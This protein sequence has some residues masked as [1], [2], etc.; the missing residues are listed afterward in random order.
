[1]LSNKY[2]KKIPPSVLRKF[3]LNTTFTISF[4]TEKKCWVR[5]FKNKRKKPKGG[6]FMVIK[7]IATILSNASNRYKRT[8]RKF[9]IREIGNVLTFVDDGSTS[10]ALQVSLRKKFNLTNFFKNSRLNFLFVVMLQIKPL[11]KLQFII[12][13]IKKIITEKI[14]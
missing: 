13:N 12:I 5:K 10:N 1:M 2:V 3:K 11:N 7:S 9:N 8:E 6:R 14:K 4:N